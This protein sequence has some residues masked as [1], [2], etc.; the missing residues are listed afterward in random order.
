VWKKAHILTIDTYK[1][2]IN[3]PKDELY[4]L[5]SQIRRACISIPSNIA[6]GCSRDGKAEFGRFLQIALGSANELE[7]QFL[8]SNTLKILDSNNYNNLNSKVDE[9]RRMLISLIRKTKVG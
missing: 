9:V 8:L 4:G 2:T 1:S 5:T 6:E 3:F 7:Y